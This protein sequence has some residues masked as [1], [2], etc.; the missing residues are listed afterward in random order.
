MSFDLF[1]APQKT[2]A[3]YA[4]FNLSNNDWRDGVV[5]RSPNWLGDAAMALP[6]MYSL[7]KILPEKCGFFVV[8]PENLVSFYESIPWIDYVLSIGS[9]HS[10]W[11]P[12][13]LNSLKKLRA[14]VGMLFVNSLR[15]AYY[16][17]KGGVKKLFGASNGLRNLFLQKAFKVEWHKKTGYEECHQSYKYLN[18]VY[19]LG[20]PIWRQDFPE[21]EI[22][23]AGEINNPELKSLHK[24]KNI[25]VIQ[26]GAAYGLAK[27]WPEDF[28]AEVCK[29]WIKEKN[30]YIAIVGTREEIETAEKVKSAIGNNQRIISLTGKT[31][32]IELMYVLKNSEVCLCNDSGVMHLASALNM[33]GVAIFGS[34]DPFATGPVRGKWVVLLEKQSCSPCFSRECQNQDH[35]Y[36]CLASISPKK[37]IEALEYIIN[38]ND[39]NHS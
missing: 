17:K 9:G 11:T 5:V 13:Q 18:M 29:T 15:S 24:D 20:A 12:D 30:G 1:K 36:R 39:N 6:A 33:R 25:L 35:D 4:S 3:K 31:S 23:K 34:T 14:G 10:S 27:R 8:A 37:V 38:Y 7:K 26:P 28:F 21:F 32:L 22:P 16:F 19:A 2:S